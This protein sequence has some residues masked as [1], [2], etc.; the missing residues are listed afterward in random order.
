MRRAVSGL[1]AWLVQRVS[2]VYMLLFLVFVLAYFL[3]DLPRSYLAWH[4]W[5]AH[6]VVSSAA[7]VFFAA[8]LA[9]MWVGLRDVILD[10]VKPLAVRVGALA[11][12]A[13]GLIGLG[14]WVIRILWRAHG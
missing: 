14:A 11:L 9:H 7:F 3:L 8:L 2:A 4:T 6:P 5:I 10:Y 12:L 13:L 1:R